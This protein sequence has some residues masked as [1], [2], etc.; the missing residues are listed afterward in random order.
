MMLA[1]ALAAILGAGLAEPPPVADGRE[2]LVPS[3]AE[4][5]FRIG[6]G[7]RP[8]ASRLSFSPGFGTLGSRKIYTIRLAYNPHPWLGWEA[9]FGHNPGQSV[10]ALLHTFSAVMRAP[11]P[12]RVQPYGSVGCGMIMV[13]PGD[14]LNSDPVTRSALTAGGGLELYIRDDVAVRLEARSVGLLGGSG[15]TVGALQ[16]G[17]ATAALSFYR[18]IDR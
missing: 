17:E 8:Y 6:D 7:P 15:S 18:S 12:W 10:H 2:W 3:L 11:L 14:T 16:Y 9:A 13:Y 1:A 4:N 5:P